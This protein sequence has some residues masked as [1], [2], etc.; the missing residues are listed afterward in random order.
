MLV[1]NLV[2]TG[3]LTF[4]TALPISGSLL[5][6]GSIGIGNPSPNALLTVGSSSTRGNIQ[7]IGTST[8]A[9]VVQLDATTQSGGH[10]WA[11]YAGSSAAG[12]FEIA[13]ITAAQ[14]RLAIDQNGQ[15][16]IGSVPPA[17]WYSANVRALQVGPWASLSG[18]TSSGWA[19]LSQNAVAA[20]NANDNSGWV[21]KSSNQATALQLANGDIYFRGAPV[22]TSGS[23][24][25]WNTS[26]FVSGSGNVG[27]GTTSPQLNAN[28]GTFTTIHSAIAS[29][30]LELST[31]TVIDGNGG[32]V[33]FNNTN[34]AGADKR[35]AQISGIRDGVNSNGTLTFT[36]WNSGTGAERMRIT[37]SGSVGIGTTAP[38]ASLQVSNQTAGTATVPSLGQTGSYTSL[39]LSNLNYSYG[40][41]MGS[42]ND[43]SSWIQAQRTDGTATAYNLQLQPNGG[44][45]ST[46]T[47]INIHNGMTLDSNN[48]S[49]DITTSYVSIGPTTQFV[50]LCYVYWADKSSAQR[51]YAL[52]SMNYY[53][54]GVTTISSSNNAGNGVVFQ[55][56]G[57]NLQMKT[58]SGTVTGTQVTWFKV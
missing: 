47:S 37:S 19:T 29:S 9:P 44:G 45:I 50:A 39:Y 26:M 24:I 49:S 18:N 32:V 4:P 15:A 13:D 21:Y 52:L 40:M 43:G 23:A 12:I 14:T 6:S 56:S 58:T 36:T 1:H 57:Q 3:S 11:L 55:V 34:I 54:A 7:V 25:T 16:G 38:R 5:V 51:D 42:I 46:G 41:L 22:G 27:I 10:N 53:P 20:T 35:N 31:S 17:N 28:A 2:V 48:Y 30:W 8:G 33:S